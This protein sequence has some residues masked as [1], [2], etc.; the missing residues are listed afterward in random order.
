[1]EP[2][3]TIE[4]IDEKG[5]VLKRLK[6][7]SH[8]ATRNM[9]NMFFAHKANVVCYDTAY[10][11]SKFSARQDTGAAWGQNNY[12][13]RF[14]KNPITAKQDTWGIL[15]GA[16]NAA[17]EWSQYQLQAK[18]SNG[19]STGKIYYHAHASSYATSVWA[20]GTRTWSWNLSRVLGNYAS[21]PI[22]IKEMAWLPDIAIGGWTFRAMLYRDVLTSPVTVPAGD[23]VKVGYTIVSPVVPS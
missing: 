21:T 14:C 16:T 12:G 6:R 11:A 13:V 7:R 3:L 18:I 1:M 8:T 2:Y 4:V 23:L 5:K 9:Y 15:V 19:A 22:T 10:T 17:F 20:S